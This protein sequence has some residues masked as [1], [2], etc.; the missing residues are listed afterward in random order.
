MGAPASAR[1]QKD[2]RDAALQRE[3]W[4]NVV[5]VLRSPRAVFA[6]MRDDSDEAAGARQE[7]ALLLLLVS[8]VAAVLSFSDATR[9]LLDDRD[10]DGIVVLVVIFLGGALYGIAGYWLGGLALH[11]GVHGAKGEGSYRLDRHLLAFALTPLALSLL[12]VWPIRLLA[13]QGDNFERGGSDD[14]AAG[15][16]FTGLALAFLAWSL[17]LLFVGIRVVHGFTVIRSL[18]ALLLSAMALGALGLVAI[19]LGAQL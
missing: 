7:P 14:G 6:A 9:T 17:A 16:A 2:R 4:W 11:M 12:V 3:W 8:G 10:A 1:R 18:G 19:L 15:W 5:T 13:F